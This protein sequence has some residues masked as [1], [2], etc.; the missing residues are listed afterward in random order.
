MKTQ[1]PVWEMLSGASQRTS[2]HMPG[3]K[4]RSPFGVR[5]LYALDTTELPITDDLYSPER[6]LKEAQ[7][8]YARAAGSG[9]ALFLHNGSTVGNHILLQLYAR[10]GDLVLLPRNAHLSAVNGCVLGGLR[11]AWIPA[12]VTE[13]DYAYVAE[14]D[15]LDT[16]ERYPQAKAVFLTRPDYYG[17]CLPLERIAARAHEM[18]MKLVVDEAHGA[19]LPWLDTLPDAG[20]CGADAWVQS[21]HKLLPGLTGSAVLHLRNPEEEPAARRILRREQTSSPSFLLMLSIDDSRALMEKEGPARLRQLIARLADLR[22]RLPMWGYTDCF[23]KWRSLPLTFD[24]TRLVIEAPQGGHVLAEQLQKLGIDAEMADARRC[25]LLFSVM[26]EMEEIDAVE[27]ALETTSSASLRSAPSPKGE[28]LDSELSNQT[29][30]FRERWY[31]ARDEVVLSLRAAAMAEGEWVPLDRAE[32]RVAGQSMGLY[33]PGIPLAVPGERI[34][35]EI[36]ERLNSA[37]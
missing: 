22:R 14:R 17:G 20:R 4:G 34:T 31:E 10:E 25:V 26:T 29:F 23:E 7:R 18:G 36:M 12:R 13:D 3:H 5:D 19:H 27:R 28:G 1:R 9:A 2:G 30:P 11:A 33:P 21:V 32:G 35:R 8:L 24:P 16:M 6:G 37:G 15:V